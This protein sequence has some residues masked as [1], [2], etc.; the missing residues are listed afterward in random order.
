MEALQQPMKVM[1][2][3]ETWLYLIGTPQRAKTLLDNLWKLDGQ[4]H[5]GCGGLV[6]RRVCQICQHPLARIAIREEDPKPDP[7]SILYPWLSELIY[8]DES[9]RPALDAWDTGA[10][11]KQDVKRFAEWILEQQQPPV[12]DSFSP[13]G[14]LGELLAKREQLKLE[15]IEGAQAPSFILPQFRLA[16]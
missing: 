8:A 11:T 12:G 15:T 14:W 1:N 10:I 9:L 13:D 7:V 16:A 6:K 3:V 2:V 5:R 4:K